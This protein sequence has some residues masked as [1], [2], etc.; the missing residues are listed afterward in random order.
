MF[1]YDAERLRA[2]ILEVTHSNIGQEAW[3]WLNEKLQS[4]QTGVVNTAFAMMPRKTGKLN[5]TVGKDVLTEINRIK[6]GFTIEGWTA[7]GLGRLCLLINLDTSDKERYIKV[8]ENLF[9]AAEV[10]ELFA[11]Y[12]SLPVFAWPESW[13]LRCAEGVRSNIGTVLEAIMY[14]NPYPSQ[15]LDQ[16]AWNQLIL[17]AFF[18]DKDIIQIPGIEKR[19][20]AE[21]ANTLRDY[22]HERWAAQR[23][24]NPY[25]WLFA[26]NFLNKDY[27]EDLQRVLSEG[28]LREKQAA[29]LTLL[30]SG[31]ESALKLLEGHSELLQDI[32]NGKISWTKL[33]PEV[34]ITIN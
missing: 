10:S 26:A 34:E 20:N 31:S 14:H 15:Y 11:L 23:K 17:K 7:D 27:L 13:K 28:D 4:N 2:L 25:L 32:K 3:L 33:A 8:I 29:A 16:Q 12:A 30:H 19:A 18:T 5:I 1:D 6:P 9:L 21:L 24:I 22:A